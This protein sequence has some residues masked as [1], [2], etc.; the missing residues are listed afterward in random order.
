MFPCVYIYVY[1]YIC[2]CFPVFWVSIWPNM[3]IYMCWHLK[4]NTWLCL[5]FYFFERIPRWIFFISSHMTPNHP[6]PHPHAEP[7]SICDS[8]TVLEAISS[9]THLDNT[10]IKHNI[11]CKEWYVIFFL[12]R[13]ARPTPTYTHTHIKWLNRIYTSS[14]ILWVTLC[15]CAQTWIGPWEYALPCQDVY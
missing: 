11:A 15:H 3:T 10:R 7:R 4:H 12:P 13:A 1:I 2:V 14:W 6:N 8:K 9:R 5:F